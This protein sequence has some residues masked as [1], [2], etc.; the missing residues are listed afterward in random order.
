MQW[1]IFAE[2]W[3]PGLDADGLLAGL[4][5]QGDSGEGF[6]F[7]AYELYEKVEANYQ[8]DENG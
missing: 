7:D 1:K 4:N 5:W 8:G 2:K 3:L 6:D